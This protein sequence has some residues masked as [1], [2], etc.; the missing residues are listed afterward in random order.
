VNDL[1]PTLR[2]IRDF[3]LKDA[4]PSAP[5]VAHLHRKGLANGQRLFG[6]TDLRRHLDNPFF[7]VDYLTLFLRGKPVDLSEARVYKVVQRRKLTFCDRRVLDRYFAD[8]AACVLEGLDILDPGVN[9]FA[10]VLDK[11]RPAT[12]CNATA[13]YSQHGNEAYRG[14]VDTDDVLVMHVEGRKRWRFH[15]RQSP[16]RI[17]L[18]DLDAHR[19]GPV[20]AEVVMEPG[21]VLYLKSF[22]PHAVETMTPHSLHVSF[23]LCDRQPS[24]EAVLSLLLRHFDRNAAT[25]HVSNEEALAHLTKLAQGS[26]YVEELRELL[27][28]EKSGHSLFRR[29]LSSNRVIHFDALAAGSP[30]GSAM[31]AALGTIA[32]TSVAKPDGSLKRSSGSDCTSE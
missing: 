32:T 13:F 29:L 26:P 25:P 15:A 21:D 27:A 4:L 10:S 9:A 2:N 5:E 3:Y 24:I 18:T 1:P 20:I 8:G 16:R 17:E 12:F 28:V 7:D 30:A 23:D 6:M 11:A 14:H 19:M 22:T 31:P